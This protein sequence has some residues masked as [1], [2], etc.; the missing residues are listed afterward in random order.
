MALNELMVCKAYK[1]HVFATANTLC[2]EFTSNTTRFK[3]TNVLKTIH[4]PPM[5]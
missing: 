3:S 2:K 5:Q 1:S 4:V